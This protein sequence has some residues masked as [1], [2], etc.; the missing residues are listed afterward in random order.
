M[1]I[2]HYQ[3]SWVGGEKW[4]E[5]SWP[6]PDH[7]GE[8]WDRARLEKHYAPWAELARRGVGVHCGEGG[9]FKFTPHPVVLAWLR[10]VLEI[11]TSHGIGF[12]L[13][14]LRGSFGILDSDR[15]DVAYEDWHGHKLDR[16]LLDLLRRF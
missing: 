16:K 6:G 9:A 11:L 1:G 3:A 2:S 15:K 4:A 8:Y 12:A 10:D 5:P 14:N 7:G 13:W